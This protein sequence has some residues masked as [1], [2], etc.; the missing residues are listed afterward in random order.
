MSEMANPFNFAQNVIHMM[1]IMEHFRLDI[2]E[3]LSYGVGGMTYDDVCERVLKG[4]YHLYP[5]NESIII[6]EV[7]AYPSCTA[8]HGVLAAGNLQEIFSSGPALER[9]ARMYKCDKMEISGRRGWLG[10]AKQHGWREQQVVV[11]KPLNR[12]NEVT[13]EQES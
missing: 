10:L 8:Y 6:M 9:V 1:S 4:Q 7:V 3:A 13:D 12:P 2:E 11:E 5:M